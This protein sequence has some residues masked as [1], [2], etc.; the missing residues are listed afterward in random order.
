MDSTLTPYSQQDLERI[1]NYLLSDLTLGLSPAKTPTAYLLGGQ[2]GAG[3]SII[4]RRLAKQYQGNIILI[5]ADEFRKFHPHF[6][7]LNQIYGKDAVLHTQEFAG[8]MTEL[9]IE[10]LS[11]QKFNLMI[12]GTLRTTDVPLKTQE[13]LAKKGYQVE[14]LVM[15]VK[16][17]LSYVCTILRYE[18]MLAKGAAARATPKAHHDYIAANIAKNLTELYKTGKFENIKI[19]DRRRN[20][21]YDQKNTPKKDPGAVLHH[22]LYGPW[23]YFEKKEIE[24]VA[25][26][27]VALLK[28]RNAPELP[29][30]LKL[31][32]KI[33]RI[34]QNKKTKA[35]L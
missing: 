31:C 21:L 23:S 13:R 30:F 15:A 7:Q 18:K 35:K 29:Q 26:Q 24:T 25:N 27:I 6:R 28:Q 17:L 14:L 8:R 4:S 34:T 20:C 1:S 5:N 11:S 33:N 12:E 3:K 19:Y 16:P 10:R 9:I 32:K 2:S 22:A